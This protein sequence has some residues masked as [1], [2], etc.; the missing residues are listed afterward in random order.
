MIQEIHQKE[1][2]LSDFKAL[3]HHRKSDDYSPGYLARRERSHQNETLGKILRCVVSEANHGYR[4]PTSLTHIKAN[5]LQLTWNKPSPPPTRPSISIRLY[6]LGFKSRKRCDKASLKLR[7]PTQKTDIVITCRLT[8]TYCS[9]AHETISGKQLSL[10]WESSQLFRNHPKPWSNISSY[11]YQ[12]MH[13]SQTYQ[14]L[15]PDV[16][17]HCWLRSDHTWQTCRRP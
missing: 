4:S 6:K 13:A 16:N 3:Q 14:T 17:A 15:S 9:K 2:S 7:K 12:K 8:Y 10:I 1:S 11:M 5:L